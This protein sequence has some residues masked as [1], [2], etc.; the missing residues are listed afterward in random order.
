MAMSMAQKLNLKGQELTVLNAPEGYT[1]ALAGEL[2]GVAL[3]GDST[4]PGGAVLLFVNSLDEAAR[5]APEAAPGNPAVCSGR[6]SQGHV[7]DQNRRNR[8]KLPVLRGD[9]RPRPP[10]GA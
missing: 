1:T 10:G 4:A 3:S 5:L 9:W 2:P 6:L 7:E 8:D